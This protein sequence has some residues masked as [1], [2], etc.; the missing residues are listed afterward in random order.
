MLHENLIVYQVD[1]FTNET[2]KGNPAGVCIVDKE[3]DTALMQNIALEMNLSETAFIRKTGTSFE[4]RYF[5]P[6]IEV[7]LC[8]HATLGS[9]HILYSTGL[10]NSN[11]KIIFNAKAGELIVKKAGD[12]ITMNFPQYFLNKIEVPA[13]FEQ[14][15]G[16]KPVEAYECDRGWKLLAFNTVDEIVNMKPNFELLKQNEL[17]HIMVTAPS[18]REGVDYVHRCFVPDVGINEDPVTGSAQC[19]LG[20]YW[21]LKTGK[22]NFVAHQLSKRTG[23]LKVDV[24]PERVEISGQAIT[25]F[26]AE[27]SI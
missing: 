2:F 12:W 11:E 26:K 27:F 25:V 10:V 5:T 15:I 7:P 9:S 24:L 18:K 6:E 22:T 1:A 4:I 8:G 16:I 14:I 21:K 23:I 3:L 17:G 13:A 19:A 20:P